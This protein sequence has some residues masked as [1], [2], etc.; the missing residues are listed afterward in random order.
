MNFSSVLTRDHP[1]VNAVLDW[2]HS[3]QKGNFTPENEK[4]HAL[5][6]LFFCAFIP[7]AKELGKSCNRKWHNVYLTSRNLCR[8]ARRCPWNPRCMRFFPRELRDIINIII[9]SRHEICTHSSCV[10]MPVGGRQALSEWLPTWNG[11][12]GSPRPTPTW[13]LVF[14]VYATLPRKVIPSSST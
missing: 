1:F 8:I 9:R 3:S 6:I 13:G 12:R 11:E 10:F 7:V 14:D 4:V 5:P 2:L